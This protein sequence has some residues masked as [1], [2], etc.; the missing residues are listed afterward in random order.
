MFSDLGVGIL[1]TRGA[2]GGETFVPSERDL[3]IKPVSG[4][5]PSV[6]TALQLRLIAAAIRQVIG[7]LN[8]SSTAN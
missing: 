3:S 6:Q 7:D 1:S 2:G 4:P 8:A 5:A